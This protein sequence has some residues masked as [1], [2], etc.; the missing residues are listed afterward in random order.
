[1]VM[2]SR[3]TGLLPPLINRGQTARGDKQRIYAELNSRRAHNVHRGDKNCV[4]SHKQLANTSRGDNQRT[5][6]G[7]QQTYTGVISGKIG[8]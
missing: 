1:M 2:C 5:Y 8:C 3:V 6:D 4:A 7:K